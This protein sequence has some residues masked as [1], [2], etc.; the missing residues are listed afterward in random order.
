MK[1]AKSPLTGIRSVLPGLPDTGQRDK[2]ITVIYVT[3]PDLKTA[4]RIIRG[5]I[6]KQLAAC[7]NIFS[8]SSVFT[9]KGRIEETREYGAMIKTVFKHYPKAEK[10]IREHHPYEVPEII[11]WP[12]KRGLKKYLDW[13]LKETI[14]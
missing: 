14:C 3:F 2:K 11:C 7:G 8:V 13:I 12:I 10:Y 6:S 1:R 5:L 4:K 9:W